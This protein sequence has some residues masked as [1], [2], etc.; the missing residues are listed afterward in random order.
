ML[1]IIIGLQN[2]ITS[3]FLFLAILFFDYLMHL[4]FTTLSRLEARQQAC[5]KAPYPKTL[6][7]SLFPCATTKHMP[8]HTLQNRLH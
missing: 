6:E 5:I 4:T 2:L 8:F 3:C 7:P 1:G